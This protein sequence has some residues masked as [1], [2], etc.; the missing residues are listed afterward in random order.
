MTVTDFSNVSLN[1]LLA[2]WLADKIA[3]PQIQ[4]LLEQRW[5]SHSWL[6]DAKPIADPSSEPVA[7]VAHTIQQQLDQFRS[8]VPKLNSFC[9]ESLGWETFP[10]SL[11][12]DLWLPLADQLVSWHRAVGHPLIQGLMGGQGTGK[13]TLAKIL[14]YILEQQGLQVCR[15]SIDDLYKTYADRQQLQQADPRFRWRGPPGTH[16]VSLGL[17]VLEQLRQSNPPVPIAIPRFDKS[18]HQGAGDRIDP[19]WSTGADIVLFEGWFVGV[20]PIDPIAFETA[21]PPICSEADRAFARGVNTRLQEYLPLWE[22]LD[23]L[24]LLYPADYRLSQQWRQQAEQNMI[25]SGKAGMSDSE[26]RE[27]VEYFWK[28]LHPELFIAPMRHQANQ[29]D[30]VI[31]INADHCPDRLYCPAA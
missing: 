17:T 30:L 25:A 28:S 4:P 13:T 15:L 11:M 31:E 23:R 27:F 6:T 26:I 14:G 20:R 5:L 22:K 12:W 19:E 9:Q 1:N 21:P 29:V 24:I 18:L 2:D 7:A 16:D 10:L 8:L 3:T